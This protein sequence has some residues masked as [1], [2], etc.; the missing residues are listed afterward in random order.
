MKKLAQNATA[1]ISR[2]IPERFRP[3]IVSLQ[4]RTGKLVDVSLK[5]IHYNGQ[6]YIILWSDSSCTTRKLEKSAENIVH[7]LVDKLDVDPE[8]A[9]FLLVQDGNTF[10]FWRWRFEWVGNSPLKPVFK[11]LNLSAQKQLLRSVF[12][13]GKVFS[14]LKEKLTRVA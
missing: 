13:E 6:Y 5:C 3:E 8:K 14:L 11:N 1:L 10:A 4:T 12:T 7:Q 9:T 2:K